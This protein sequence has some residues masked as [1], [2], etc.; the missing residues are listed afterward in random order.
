MT[1]QDFFETA[2]MTL[3]HTSLLTTLLATLQSRGVFSQADVNEVVDLA[4]VGVE[5]TAE[6]HPAVLSEAR[7]T[8]ESFARTM[9]GKVT[10]G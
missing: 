3:A 4:L 6:G 1:D 7:K 10:A 9:G 2:G 5:N 8:L